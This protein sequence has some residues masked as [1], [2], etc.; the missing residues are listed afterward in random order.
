M[1]V[2][3]GLSSNR[4][5]QLKDDYRLFLFSPLHPRNTLASRPLSSRKFALIPKVSRRADEGSREQ[6]SWPAILCFMPDRRIGCKAGGHLDWLAG[7]RL[8]QF[9]C[10]KRGE[11]TRMKKKQ[12]GVYRHRSDGPGKETDCKGDKCLCV[13][14]R[15]WMIQCIFKCKCK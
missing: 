1:T 15:S 11:K 13:C 4:F 3:A 6:I 8:E 10:E 2:V 12:V 7:K 9:G 5:L 14:M